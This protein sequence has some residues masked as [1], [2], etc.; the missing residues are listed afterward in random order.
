L[1][2]AAE[3]DRALT[4]LASLSDD[5][6]AGA[7][8]VSV[9][10]LSPAHGLHTL[11]ELRAPDLLVIGA[12]RRSDLD[13]MFSGDDTREVLEGA[14][15]RVAIAP[16]GYASGPHTF[17]HVGVA[18]DASPASDEA[19]E[20][21]RTLAAERR[22][23]LSAFQAVPEP[24]DLQDVWNFGAEIDRRVAAARERIAKLGFVEANAGYGDVVEELAAYE[25]SVDLLVIGS[26]RYTLGDR[27]QGGS[28]AQA[29]ADHPSSPLLVLP[30]REITTPI[31]GGPDE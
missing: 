6:D 1:R 23:T 20:V 14:T 17:E 13:R 16:L 12:S 4:A 8:L 18:Y 19:L 10:A 26:H 25:A 5:A 29:L 11:V 22:A 30:S 21:A 24:I 7:E 28:T 27:L 31:Q 15:C 9:K 3:R 2:E